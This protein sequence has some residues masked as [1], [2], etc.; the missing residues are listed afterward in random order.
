MNRH[1]TLKEFKDLIEA[2]SGQFIDFIYIRGNSYPGSE[3]L[4]IK[5]TQFRV[6]YV[7]LLAKEQIKEVSLF[8][9]K[10][11]S[12]ILTP[13]KREPQV[14]KRVVEVVCWFSVLLQTGGTRYGIPAALMN[15]T[16]RRQFD[17]YT[18]E[19]NTRLLVGDE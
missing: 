6:D 8:V 7:S 11:Y 14:T 5:R 2:S 9:Y 10:D 1:V 17:R 4:K 13:D 18:D 16:I 3:E 12:V 15:E 19:L